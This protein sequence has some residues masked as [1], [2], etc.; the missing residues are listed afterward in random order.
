MAFEGALLI[1]G[2]SPAEL[3]G[4]LGPHGVELGQDRPDPHQVAV[5]D[6]PNLILTD[7]TLRLAASDEVDEH[8]TFGEEGCEFLLIDA[9]RQ[10]GRRPWPSWHLRGSCFPC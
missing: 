8:L 4:D 7:D 5:L 6:R 9:G 3:R 10:G 2:C 1:G